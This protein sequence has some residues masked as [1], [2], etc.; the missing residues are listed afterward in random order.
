[1]TTNIIF[2]P[3]YWNFSAIQERLADEG[4]TLTELVH[5][6]SCRIFC[7]DESLNLGLIG[8]LLGFGP[9]KSIAKNTFVDS[10][11]VDVNLG[12]RTV[13]IACSLVNSSRKLNRYQQGTQVI[14]T[15]PLP[16][17]MTPNGS[18]QNFGVQKW[19]ASTTRGD[20]QSITFYVNDNTGRELTNLFAEFDLTIC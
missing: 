20:F 11:T 1:M 8:E 19:T 18:I 13:N 4:V 12:V 7:K 15:I 9:N 10:N 17:N 3:G 16:M 14:A 5:D 6:N 2:Q